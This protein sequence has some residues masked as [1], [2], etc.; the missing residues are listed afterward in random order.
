[1][2]NSKLDAALKLAAQGYRIF[3]LQPFGKR[4][5]IDG[6]PRKA[7]RDPERIRRWWMDKITEW[8]QDWNIGIATG[9]GLVALDVDNKGE[10]KGSDTL[11][12][13]EILHGDLPPCPVNETPTGGRHHLFRS[14]LEVQNSA[15][16]IGPGLDVRG[17]HG[18]IVGP[19]SIVPEGTYRWSTNCDP[20]S[21]PELPPYLRE[22]MGVARTRESMKKD[23]S[24]E[25]DT[26]DNV[27]R[28]TDYLTGTAT[29][30]I[31]FQ[32]GNNQTFKTAAYVAD[33]GLSEGMTLELMLEHYNPRCDPEWTFDEIQRIVANA[34]QYRQEP[35]GSKTPESDFEPTVERDELE[36]I[37]IDPFDPREL[38]R[39][40]WLMQDILQRRNLSVLVAP[41]G[42]GKSTFVLGVMLGLVTGR[43]DITG[44]E[45]KER[46]RVWYYNNEDE[47]DELKRRLAAMMQAHAVRWSDTKVDNKL[48][49]HMNS[50]QQRLLCFVKRDQNGKLYRTK[51]YRKIVRYITEHN[52]SVFIAD[53]LQELHEADENNNVEMRYVGETLRQ[54]SWE[55]GCAVLIPHHTRKAERASSDGHAGEMDSG[56]GASAIQGVS[57][58]WL[59]LYNM[60]EK[61]AKAMGV[62]THN[63][64]RYVRLDL[65][66]NN[67]TL[68]GWTHWYRRVSVPLG[69][70]EFRD[71][72]SQDDTAELVGAL[73]PA[74]LAHQESLQ[75]KL[76][77]L[78]GAFEENERR[79]PIPTLA[80]RLMDMPMYEGY[81]QD[82]LQ[83]ALSKMF[84]G[85]LEHEDMTYWAEENPTKKKGRGGAPA[86]YVCRKP[87]AAWWEKENPLG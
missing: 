39:R 9:R 19:G 30:A 85:P 84:F 22:R 38:P 79:I 53:P 56:R 36:P 54:I 72:D 43:D 45:I 31:A 35:A 52:I 66:K 46:C 82:N 40:E 26:P 48:A 63:R 68:S 47:S 13:L 18:Y 78:A 51:D 1:M 34:W 29:P 61:D 74:A 8:E 65:A 57:R 15:S 33:F 27:A 64:R 5:A 62:T 83:E 86:M 24:A 81:R 32:G 49:L 67:H 55:T 23:A 14:S 4:P 6:W 21:P 50:G 60:S 58:A 42:T 28:A 37:R 76:E 11:A 44:F 3:P 25:L 80:R 41:S 71:D 7:T 75:I 2:S 16:E 12:E 20:T 59:T 69:Y 77:D 73:V 70:P 17:H 10:V 87:T